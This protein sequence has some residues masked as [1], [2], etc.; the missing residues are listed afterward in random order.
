M[1]Q[2]SRA[3]RKPRLRCR[4]WEVRKGVF[5]ADKWLSFHR[6]LVMQS[7]RSLTVGRLSRRTYID[8]SRRDMHGDIVYDKKK[9]VD[10]SC[11]FSDSLGIG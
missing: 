9:A 10:C 6:R 7:V 5:V 1:G 2:R 11:A 8:L 4:F 3:T